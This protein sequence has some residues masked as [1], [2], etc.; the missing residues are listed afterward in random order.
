[1][2]MKRLLLLL[3]MTTLVSALGHAGQPNEINY[4]GVV[5][6]DLGELFNGTDV[7][8]RY[9]LW[10]DF[11]AGSIRWADVTTVDI[12]DG[13][14]VHNMGSIAPIPDTLFAYNDSL[15]LE[16]MIDAEPIAPRT[17]MTGSAYSFAVK[18]IHGAKGGTISGDILLLS[19]SD[20]NAMEISQSGIGR[21][22]RIAMNNALSTN[23]ALAI[24]SQNS[25]PSILIVNDGGGAAIDVIS[26]FGG[27]ATV[28]LPEGSISGFEILNGT[29]DNSDL[30]PNSVGATELQ[31]NSVGTS[32]IQNNSIT[33]GDIQ[34]NT[35]LAIDIA[36]NGVNSAEI[37]SNAV[38]TSEIDNLSILNVDVANDEIT[39]AKLADEAGVAQT[40]TSVTFNISTT[41]SNVSSRTMTL[42]ASG[43]V[44]V[45]A[46]AEARVSHVN[47]TGSG[48]E[49]GVNDG[50]AALTPDQR[51]RWYI[52]AN[53]PTG[54]YRA[55]L[56]SQKIFQSNSGNRTFYAVADKTGGVNNFFFTDI[57]LSM[58]YFP[59]TY[60]GVSE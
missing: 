36:T 24:V 40:V 8:V 25:A 13:I 27:D 34:D 5:R 52:S 11:T 21:G 39:A 45:M 57:T 60:G 2:S 17:L 53:A 10:D 49:F 42:P 23:A 51:K 3:A 31:T 28:N 18:S 47:G 14:L 29:I 1:M 58:A 55:I 50:S 15:W 19:Q 22:L 35:I 33:S 48:V 43:Y 54:T 44:L 7:S 9:I 37:A 6:D 56:S 20:V 30:A 16:I 38:G 4:Q 46:T 12:V 59:T 41:A 26:P 32:E